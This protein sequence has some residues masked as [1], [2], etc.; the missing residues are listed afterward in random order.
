MILKEIRND[1]LKTKNNSKIKILKKFFKTNKGEYGEN[2]NFISATSTP[3]IRKISKKYYT[4][5]NFEQLQKLIK[6]KYHEERLIAILIL[7][8][9]YEKSKKEKNNKITKKIFN[10]Y[11][12]N[13]DYINNWDLVDISCYK[14][15]GDYLLNKK[16]EE[17]ILCKLAKSNKK[18]NS[19]WQWL[20]EKRIS[21][22]ST[23]IFIKNNEFDN[24]LKIS[25]ILLKEKHDLIHKAVGWMLREV[26]KKNQ[27]IL[28]DFLKKN[29][30]LIPRTTLR[31][32]IEKFS[33]KKRQNILKGSFK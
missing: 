16:N 20:W 17:K 10:F 26:G 7:I 5:L 15:I 1:L 21:I 28:I 8:K 23:L 32:S 18:K 13:T 3:I 33:K 6:S 12:K 27:K 31:Y 9:K 29:Y 4:Q 19:G 14:I 30:Y 2:D 11:L 25:K 22:V 24:T